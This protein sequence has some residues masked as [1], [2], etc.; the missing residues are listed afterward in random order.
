MANTTTEIRY[1]DMALWTVGN[2]V[3]TAA[4]KPLRDDLHLADGHTLGFT[5]IL[6]DMAF[7]FTLTTDATGER[8]NEKTLK[9]GNNIRFPAVLAAATGLLDAVQ[10]RS[11]ARLDFSRTDGRRDGF[12]VAAQP[13][14]RPEIA[15]DAGQTL[16][17][18][19]AEK[20]LLEG[21]MSAY[22]AE[23][24]NRF[25]NALGLAVQDPVRWYLS[26]RDGR[27]ALVGDFDRQ[28]IPDE[29]APNVRTVQ[30]HASGVADALSDQYRVYIPKALIDALYWET[31]KLRFQLERQRIVVQPALDADQMADLEADLP[32]DSVPGTESV[33]A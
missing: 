25:V 9:D 31:L 29:D 22:G 33:T 5:P 20:Q 30:V 10:N 8:V 24:D 28:R 2:Q 32:L 18:A 7:Q 16:D 11:E 15:A 13:P 21:E 26:V 23:L 3:E 14:L 12:T 4:P 1:G 17:V 6:E 27:F 19:P